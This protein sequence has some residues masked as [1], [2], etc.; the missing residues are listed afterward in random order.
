MLDEIAVRFLAVAPEVDFWSLR[1]VEDWRENITVRRDVLE[2]LRQRSSTGVM[3]TVIHGGGAGY[4]STSDLSEAGLR[5]AALSAC[6]WAKRTAETGIVETAISTPPQRGHYQTRVERDWESMSLGDKISLLHTLNGLLR[7]ARSNKTGDPSRNALD[8]IVDWQA[9]LSHRLTRT[10]LVSSDGARIE[11]STSSVCPGLAVAANEGSETQVRTHGFGN[12]A[13]QGGLERLA[14]WQL[15]ATAERLS[16]EALDLL[17]A[18]ECPSGLTDV[19]IMPAQMAIQ[20]HESIG[21]PLELDRILGDERNYAGT[22]FVTKQMFGTYRYGSELLN[23]TFD[24]AREGELASYA[25]DDDGT[26]AVHHFII[27]DG[28]LKRPLGSALSQQRAGLPG[29]ANARASDWNRPPIDRMANLNMLPGGDNMA[30]LVASIDCGVLLDTNRSWSID[31]SRNKFQFGCEYGRIIENGE[32]KGMV[33]NANYRGVS[34]T[35]WRSLSN[36]GDAST[37]EVCGTTSC[38]KGEPNQLISV[39]HAAPACVFR[40]V[41]VFSGP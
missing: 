16:R 20:I 18:P 29:V 13:Q 30:Q 34:A 37:F 8:R 21:H 35:F 2:P 27:K 40:N 17:R 10:L 28:I 32:L 23:I 38:G 31:D 24:P 3:V 4:A 15:E 22:S 25:F 6:A 11:Q 7:S 14:E 39:G 33:K 1:S 9:S 26:R 5:Q 36:V 41:D 12:L 19:L